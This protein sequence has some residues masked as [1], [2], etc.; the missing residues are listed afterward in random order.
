MYD[1]CIKI[2]K[3]PKIALVIASIF[4]EFFIKKGL[5]IQNEIRYNVLRLATG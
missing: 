3:Y 1:I 4:M 5:V 2:K